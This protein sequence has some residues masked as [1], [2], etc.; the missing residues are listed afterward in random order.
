MR[1]ARADETSNRKVQAAKFEG[2]APRTPTIAAH[3]AH[4]CIEGSSYAVDGAKACRVAV[5]V[6]DDHLPSEVIRGHQGSSESCRVAVIVRDD[7]LPSEV[8]RGH[9]GSSEVIRG[10]Q[11]SSEV[12]RGHQSS[13][14]LIRA[15]QSS[16]ELIR[17]H[18]SS[19]PTGREIESRARPPVTCTA[20]PPAQ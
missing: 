5:I 16:S 4:A 2:S 17:G 8:I 12:I 6:C 20:A 9:Q 14:E 15:H 18:Q 10:H 1:L 7:H 11:R 19:L 13:S 3:A